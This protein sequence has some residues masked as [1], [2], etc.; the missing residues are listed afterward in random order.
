MLLLIPLLLIVVVVLVRP[1]LLSNTIALVLFVCACAWGAVVV[2]DEVNWAGIKNSL[3]PL[4]W[5]ATSIAC[6]F[7]F[8]RVIS[9]IRARKETRQ[10]YQVGDGKPDA[11]AFDQEKKSVARMLKAFTRYLYS[12][13]NSLLVSRK[14]PIQQDQINLEVEKASERAALK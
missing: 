1:G 12:Y 4:A 9:A 10:R 2:Y 5:I 13:T 8:A 3:A 7:L 11:G 14:P 6:L